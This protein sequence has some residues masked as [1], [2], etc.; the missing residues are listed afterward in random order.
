MCEGEPLWNCWG[1]PKLTLLLLLLLEERLEVEAEGD[2]LLVLLFVLLLLL[3]PSTFSSVSPELSLPLG[4]RSMGLVLTAEVLLP[5]EGDF[6]G[7]VCVVLADFDLEDLC[8]FLDL[9]KG[10]GEA[11]GA[12]EGLPRAA[13]DVARA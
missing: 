5:L 1:I 7:V 4:D 3:D 11:I 12:P 2:A 13:E 10:P 6:L 9:E 8:C